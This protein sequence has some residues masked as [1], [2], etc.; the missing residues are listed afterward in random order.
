MLSQNIPCFDVPL[1]SFGGTRGSLPCGPFA[2]K[3]NE[4]SCSRTFVTSHIYEVSGANAMTLMIVSRLYANSQHKLVRSAEIVN[5]K[6]Y[7]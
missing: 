5:I 1:N 7:L 2:R 4:L 3:Y 6:W